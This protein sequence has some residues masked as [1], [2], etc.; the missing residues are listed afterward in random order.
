MDT[1]ALANILNYHVVAGKIM[2]ADLT[3]GME[4]VTVQGSNITVAVDSSGGV[5]LNAGTANEAE[6]LT[7]DI[8]A[9]NGV[10]HAISDFLVPP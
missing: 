6:V 4:L 9:S 10:I 5:T 3:N 7:A 2:A 8:Q 1:A